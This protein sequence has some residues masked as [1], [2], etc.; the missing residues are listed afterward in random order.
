MFLGRTGG[1]LCPVAAIAAYLAVRGSE[2]GPFFKFLDGRPMSREV[3]VAKVRGALEQAGLKPEKFAG[4]SFR[5]GAVTTAAVR[6]GK[7][8]S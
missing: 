8:T 5:I 1:T 6:R 4:H 3:F 7:I 2:S